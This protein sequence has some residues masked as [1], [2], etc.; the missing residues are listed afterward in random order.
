MIHYTA[1]LLRVWRDDRK[2]GGRWVGRLE[3]LDDA[4]RLQFEDPRALLTH[5]AGGHRYG[6]GPR[7]ISTRRRGKREGIR[8]DD[9]TVGRTDLSGL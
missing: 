3:H 5:L 1:Y 8:V 2:P 7:G 4:T 6:V 9:R